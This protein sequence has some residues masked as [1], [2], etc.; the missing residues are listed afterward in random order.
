MA[1]ALTVSSKVEQAYRRGD[2]FERCQRMMAA[3][4]TFCGSPKGAARSKVA[5]L[6][7]IV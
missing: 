2:M 4:S 1:L 3:W 5:M 7:Q 6:R